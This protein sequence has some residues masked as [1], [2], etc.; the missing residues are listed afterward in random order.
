MANATADRQVLIDFSITGEGWAAVALQIGDS[1]FTIDSASYTTD[2]VGDLVRAALALVTGTWFAR[3]S[4]DGEPNE[5]RLV[6]SG[7][8]DGISLRTSCSVKVLEFSD[9][10]T[11]Q[12]DQEGSPAFEAECT[13]GDFAT[14]VLEMARKVLNADGVQTYRWRNMPFPIRA[15][16]ALE[17]ALSAEVSSGSPA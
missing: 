15:F 2:V 12:P 9:I 16:R 4:F 6:V 17:A 8:V 10:N 3:V 5:W 11:E 7:P 1:S 14:A 13:V